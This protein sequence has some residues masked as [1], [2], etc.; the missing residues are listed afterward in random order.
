MPIESETADDQA[1]EMAQQEVREIEG[2]QFGLGKRSEHRAGRE[3]LVAVGA[4]NAFNPLLAQHVVQ[5]S[6]GPA[7]AVGDEDRQIAAARSL[8]EG[9]NGAGNLFRPI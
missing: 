8:N 1:L 5:Q 6:A 3:E 2:A 7:I 9:A 4:R